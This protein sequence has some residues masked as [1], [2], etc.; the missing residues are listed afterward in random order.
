[1]K[2]L[3]ISFVK[4]SLRFTSFLHKSTKLKSQRIAFAACFRIQIA[5]A[6][7]EAHV[8]N[9][10]ATAG[11]R[12][13]DD[14]FTNINFQRPVSA[15]KGKKQ[16]TALSHRSQNA[17]LFSRRCQNTKKLQANQ[18]TRKQDTSTKKRSP[19]AEINPEDDSGLGNFHE[20]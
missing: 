13:F 19:T 8:R 15:E 5:M 6:K 7:N 17:H 10:K 11:P 1:M 20:V 18:T 2:R 14:F 3:K 9:T 4:I 12:I 16:K